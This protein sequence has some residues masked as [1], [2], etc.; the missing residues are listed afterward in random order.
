MVAIWKKE[1]KRICAE[2]KFNHTSLLHQGAASLKSSRKGTNFTIRGKAWGE[3]GR[4]RKSHREKA[5]SKK[6]A[7]V[8]LET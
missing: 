2:R 8:S 6:A 1:I 4:P 5:G 3:E 7:I